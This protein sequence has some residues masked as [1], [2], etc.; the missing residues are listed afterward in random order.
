MGKDKEYDIKK[1][2]KNLEDEIE[3]NI[4]KK[5]EKKGIPIID[6]DEVIDLAKETYGQYLELEMEKIKKKYQQKITKL[7]KKN[8]KYKQTSKGKRKKLFK[9]GWDKHIDKITLNFYTIY[10][11]GDRGWCGFCR[12]FR[13]LGLE[14]KLENLHKVLNIDEEKYR[15]KLWKVDQADRFLDKKADRHYDNRLSPEGMNWYYVKGLGIRKFP[16][17][18]LVVELMPSKTQDRKKFLR[19]EGIGK[20]DE[21]YYDFGGF[22]ESIVKFIRYLDEEHLENIKSHKNNIAYQDLALDHKF[23]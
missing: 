23:K 12:K 15:F 18:D 19:R 9:N 17:F 20:D 7:K 3:K 22:L 5:K 1:M 13:E 21:G 14:A 6:E 16:A 2:R 4:S 10:V 8:K 11:K